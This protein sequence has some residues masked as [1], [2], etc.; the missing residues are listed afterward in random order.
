MPSGRV[1]APAASPGPVAQL[2]E[3]IPDK[4]EVVGS[5]PTRPTRRG[6][7]RRCPGTE[8]TK[9]GGF[10]GKLM[11]MFIA[12]I[13]AA[14][15]AVFKRPA[16]QDLDED[17][18]QSCRPCGRI[19]EPTTFRTGARAR[20]GPSRLAK[21]AYSGVGSGAMARLRRAVERDPG[22]WRSGGSRRRRRLR[23]LAELGADRILRV[24]NATWAGPEPV[25]ARCSALADAGTCRTAAFDGDETIGYVLGWVGVDPEDGLHTHSHMLAALPDRRHRG[26]GY[27]LKLAQRAG[28]RPG[29][30][31]GPVDL[32]PL[33]ARN[34]YF[35]LH[36]L[37][38]VADRFDRNHYG[39]MVDEVNAGE[40]S[41]RFT[42]PMEPRTRTWPGDVGAHEAALE[43]DGGWPG[44]VHAPSGRGALSR[45][46]ATTQG[47]GPRMPTARR[48]GVTSAKRSRPVSPPG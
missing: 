24:M 7:R 37:G 3:R 23:P 20:R 19:A 26:V 12:A 11:K 39:A 10:F 30:R 27:A 22:T 14:V 29:D 18:W 43:D 47:F 32:D 16:R 21:G 13:V 35:N 40:R 5:S 8:E 28:A 4:D 1:K 42:D 41:D 36:K 25:R 17:E 46:R 33:I 38:A 31:R 6:G 34:G 2:G 48:R 45:S 15:V 44:D 9:K